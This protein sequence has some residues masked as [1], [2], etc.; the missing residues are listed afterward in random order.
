MGGFFNQKQ[1]SEVSIH[2]TCP[3]SDLQDVY[4]HNALHCV[5]IYVAVLMSANEQFV[6]AESHVS[7]LM[8]YPSG[9]VPP[10]YSSNSKF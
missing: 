4:L 5:G 8:H 1:W 10:T 7:L 3:H 2:N 6:K 9:R